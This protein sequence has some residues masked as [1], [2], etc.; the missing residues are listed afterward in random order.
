MFHPVPR[1][2]HTPTSCSSGPS[3]FDGG[4]FRLDNLSGGGTTKSANLRSLPSCSRS[5]GS[6][7]SRSVSIAMPNLP[8]RSELAHL[9][10]RLQV[11]L[12]GFAVG[13]SPERRERD[14]I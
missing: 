6:L 14:Y 3:S 13:T 4:A 2:S 9:R 7:T 5:S 12:D 11:L 8:C 10:F 1:P